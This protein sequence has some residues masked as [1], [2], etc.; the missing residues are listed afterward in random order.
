MLE[1][2]SVQLDSEDVKR[3]KPSFLLPLK[4]PLLTSVPLPMA[5]VK[6]LS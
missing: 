5:H 4:F 1:A 3:M 2:H 6:F